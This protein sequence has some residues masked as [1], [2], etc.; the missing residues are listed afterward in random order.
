MRSALIT[1]GVRMCTVGTDV[2]QSRGAEA[3][4]RPA[5]SCMSV[6]RTIINSPLAKEDEST[7][8]ALRVG[9]RSPTFGRSRDTDAVHSLS[10]RSV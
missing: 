9:H 7:M 4:R 8:V 2:K 10:E 5:T 1:K 3:V 6:S